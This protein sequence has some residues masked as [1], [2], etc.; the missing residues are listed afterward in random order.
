M[1]CVP[2]E[3]VREY[4]A[5]ASVESANSLHLLRA[6]DDVVNWLSALGKKA[7]GDIALAQRFSEAFKQCT[8]KIPID[9]DESICVNLEKIAGNVEGIIEVMSLKKQFALDDSSLIGEYEDCVVGEY[10][11]IIDVYQIL[12]CAM[13]DLQQA[14]MEHD[15]E[16]SPVTGSFRNPDDL[17]AHL[18]SL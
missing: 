7:R 8:P 6:I 3:L 1:N 2:S 12:Y 14:V 15:A 16:L 9:S 17:V 5:S 11:N 18:K 4:C 13:E 10:T